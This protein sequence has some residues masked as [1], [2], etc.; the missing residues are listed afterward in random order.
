MYFNINKYIFLYL[1][2]SV[3]LWKKKTGPKVASGKTNRLAKA[4]GWEDRR[5]TGSFF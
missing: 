3:S 5:K 1:S 2:I 4:Q